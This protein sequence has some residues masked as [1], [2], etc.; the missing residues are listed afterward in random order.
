MLTGDDGYSLG[1]SMVGEVNGN[2]FVAFPDMSTNERF[3]S[4]KALVIGLPNTQTKVNTA[5][6]T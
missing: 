3:E 5:Q 1:F 2:F 6:G 4:V